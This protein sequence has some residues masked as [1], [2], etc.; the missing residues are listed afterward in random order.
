MSNSS[1]SDRPPQSRDEFIAVIVAFLVFGSI[2]AWAFGQGKGGWNLASLPDSLQSWVR[3]DRAS[4]D[5]NVPR[6]LI[7]LPE[8]AGSPSPQPSATVPPSP[9]ATQPEPGVGAVQRSSS[10]QAGVAGGAAVGAGRAQQP[11][12]SSEP[13]APQTSRTP[14]QFPDVPEQY[15]AAPYIAELSALGVIKGFDTGAFRPEQTVT[16]AEFAA[17]IQKAFPNAQATQN[18]IAFPDV[19]DDFWGTQAINQAVRTNFLKGYD[20]G[21][22]RPEDPVARVEVLAALVQGLGLSAA[23]QPKELLSFYDDAN[24]IP[25]WAPN[26]VATATRSGLVVNYPNPAELKPNQPAT[27]AEVAAIIYQALVQAKQAKPIQSKYV[28]SPPRL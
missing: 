20:D 13:P 27:R 1:P 16:R 18:V 4:S 9:P 6:L 11:A 26:A 17:Q 12:E 10:Y 28:V 3:S 22:F 8:A 7:P 21:Q 25:P 5:A 19:P 2:F 23:A 15:W 14:I 24:A